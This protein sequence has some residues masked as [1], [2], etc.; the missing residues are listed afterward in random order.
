MM[1]LT[2]DEILRG[3]GPGLAQSAGPMQMIPLLGEDD[4]TFAPPEI[5]VGTT[6]YGSVHLRNHS[7]RPTLVPPGAGWVV[8]Q[9]AQDHA[10]G[11]GALLRPGESRAIDTAMCIQQSQ[12]GLI[13]A[14]KHALLILPAALRAKALSVRHVQD[15]RKLWESIQE[16]NRGFGIEQ[17]GGHLEYFLRTFQKQLD[18]FVAE[19]EIVPRQVG[20]VI[21]VGGEIV[22]IERAPSAAYWKAVWNPLVRVCYGS[23]AVSA[24]REN[25]APPSTRAPLRVHVGTLAGLRAALDRAQ[26]EEQDAI[27]ARLHAERLTQLSAASDADETMGDIALTTVASLR[28]AG[29]LATVRGA[30]RYASLCRAA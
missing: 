4:D 1:S 27:A 13:S 19:F 29:Q 9:K 12:G 11:G 8:A 22:G 7:D 14:A 23:L 6:G 5:E 26:R 24:A 17:Y 30:V 18:E 28:F 2:V 21:L 20:A 25:K 3:T 10:I 16:L 15:F